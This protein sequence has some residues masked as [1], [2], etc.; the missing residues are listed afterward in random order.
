MPLPWILLLKEERYCNR[1]TGITALASYTDSL[2]RKVVSGGSK[3]LC[4]SESSGSVAQLHSFAA[5]RVLVLSRQAT[6]ECCFNPAE[7][8]KA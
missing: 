5:A 7:S 4:R 1:C 8:A 3:W 2:H 6:Q